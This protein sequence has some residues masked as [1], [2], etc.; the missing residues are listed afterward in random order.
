MKKSAPERGALQRSWSNQYR[1]EINRSV[2]MMCC[3]SAIHDQARSMYLA[4][5]VST[6]IFSPVLMNK[7]A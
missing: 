6:L 7:G 4:V 3:E 2:K 5:R 1:D